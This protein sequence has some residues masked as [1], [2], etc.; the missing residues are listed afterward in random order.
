M[1]GIG[2]ALALRADVGIDLLR[3]CVA[4]LAERQ[5]HRGPD[6]AGSWDDGRLCA[7]SHR[8]LAVI[9]LSPGG[10]QPM[11]DPTDRYTVS[12]NGELYNYRELR[13]ELE[14]YGHVFRSQSDTEV[15]LTAYAE[16]G[17]ECL[18]R[19]DGMFAFAL[20]D[21]TQRRL[22]LARDR[23]GEKPLFYSRRDGMFIAASELR[24]L[25]ALPGGA[26]RLDARGVFDYLAL[27]YVPAPRSVLEDVRALAPGSAMIVRADGAMQTFPFFVFDRAVD[28]KPQPLEETV[29]ALEEALLRSIER[30]LLSD[31]PLG[32]FLSSGVDSSL[33][34]ALAA[35]RL[36]RELRT[37]CAGFPGAATDET[38]G[39][40]RIAEALGLPHQS[41][42]L[43]SDD[44][45]GVLGRFGEHL[46]EPNGDR[47]CVPVYLLSREMRR[48]VTVAVSGDAGDELF[49]GYPRY[50]GFDR[51]R[52]G[53]TPADAL[54]GYFEGAL[55]VFAP[56]LLKALFPDEYAGWRGEFL[57]CYTPVAMR[58]GWNEAQR[59]SVLDFHSYLPGA[60]LAKVD[61][62]SMRHALEVR[63]PF[64]EPEV[65]RVAAGLAPEQCPAQGMLKPVLRELLARHLDPALVPEAK[66]GFGMPAGFMQAHQP[67]FGT[68]FASA[69][70]VLRATP[71]FA[72]R[73][74]A[75]ER[76]AQAAPGNINSQWALTVLG[77]WVDAVGIGG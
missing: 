47:S 65:M 51:L 8:R 16:W 58:A 53:R 54:E 35:R 61:R 66:T 69:C 63:T 48:E 18:A 11:S 59:L 7:L 55:P 52:E 38:V 62:M 56:S 41:Y 23:A 36:K 64:L 12:Y 76:L 40:R 25:A 75:F 20:W 30:R 72:A 31:V 74:E 33:V 2:A 1:C 26:A 68:L 10:A 17:Q 67:L 71:F 37:F 13:A 28:P 4:R 70:E 3:E 9:D 19:L 77:M 32:A 15:L 57:Q 22:L 46:D 39:A 24:A 43:S 5:A 34:C 73:R 14:T 60:V 45:L 29:D 50:A 6:G 42:A 21:T 27:R 44:L 49:C